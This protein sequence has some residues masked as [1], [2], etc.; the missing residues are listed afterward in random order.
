MHP[1]HSPPPHPTSLHLRRRRPRRVREF[2][3]Q[4]GE[5]ATAGRH[6]GESARPSLGIGP[7]VKLPL[8]KFLAP[9][10]P[11]PSTCLSAPKLWAGM[12]GHGGRSIAFPR[13]SL[14]KGERKSETIRRRP[15]VL[16]RFRCTLV[17]TGSSTLISGRVDKVNGLVL[18]LLLVFAVQRGADGND[19]RRVPDSCPAFSSPLAGGGGLDREMPPSP[20]RHG[21]RA[22]YGDRAILVTA[23]TAAATAARP[24]I[25]SQR[26][27]RCAARW[28]RSGRL[29]LR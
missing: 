24:F 13:N 11:S 16:A 19:G 21:R 25:A 26:G 28:C 9:P 27:S 17:C 29:S 15:P 10:P 7:L 4:H 2:F 22:V 1:T 18:L 12:R 8:R 6:F 14:R 20:V 5:H 23:A 3:G